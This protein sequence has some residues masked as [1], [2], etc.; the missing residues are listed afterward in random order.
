MAAHMLTQLLVLVKL[1][2]A[3][4]PDLHQVGNDRSTH[5]SR[6]S[7]PCGRRHHVSNVHRPPAIVRKTLIRM[8]SFGFTVCGSLSSTT[9]SANFPM[10]RLP[11]LCSSPDA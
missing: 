4:A 9:R 3:Q 6:L 2:F 7:V 8:I 11:L 10:S 1:L 5:T